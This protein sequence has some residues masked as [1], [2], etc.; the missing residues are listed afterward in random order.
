MLFYLAFI[1]FLFKIFFKHFSLISVTHLFY[2]TC[3]SI[4]HKCMTNPGDRMRVFSISHCWF[5]LFYLFYLS[6]CWLNVK[7]FKCAVLQNNISKC[8][9]IGKFFKFNCFATQSTYSINLRPSSK[10]KYMYIVTY[11]PFILYL[12]LLSSLAC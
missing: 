7:W 3:I 12:F 5:P 1:F 4:W 6:L 10:T 8:I 9:F 2:D 11:S